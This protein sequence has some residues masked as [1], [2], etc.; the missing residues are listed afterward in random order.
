VGVGIEV[1]CLGRK[2]TVVLGCVVQVWLGIGDGFREGGW[3]G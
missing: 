1:L 3:K 2:D